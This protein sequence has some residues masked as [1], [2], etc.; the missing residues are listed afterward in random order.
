M[1]RPLTPQTAIRQVLAATGLR[2]ATG[3]VIVPMGL[4]N[5][6]LRPVF[7]GVNVITSCEL[8]AREGF[9][10]LSLVISLLGNPLALDAQLGIARARLNASEIQ[11]VLSLLAPPAVG[12]NGMPVSSQFVR[13]LDMLGHAALQT[14]AADTFDD[15]LNHD[16]ATE[17]P[18]VEDRL[19]ADRQHRHS[20]Q[21]AHRRRAHPRSVHHHTRDGDQKR[22]RRPLR[23]AMDAAVDGARRAHWRSAWA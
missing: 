13:V 8:T 22:N 4:V 7:A 17:G 15:L 19:R 5:E 23:D 10:E 21:P 12:V 6:S 16:P 1:T 18:Q 9:A 2:L 11:L 3:H 14:V 20:A